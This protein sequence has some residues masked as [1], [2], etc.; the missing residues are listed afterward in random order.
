ML[1]MLNASERVDTL[2]YLGAAA[3]AAA[4][5]SV[6]GRG[7]VSAVCSCEVPT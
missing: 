6:A 1:I 7:D 3:A 4:A 5:S 2:C